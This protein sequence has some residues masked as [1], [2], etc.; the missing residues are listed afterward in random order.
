MTNIKKD[1]FQQGQFSQQTSSP[2]CATKTEIAEGRFPFLLLLL[3]PTKKRKKNKRPEGDICIRPAM[4]H[5]AG[6]ESAVSLAKA[7]GVTRIWQIL[8]GQ[9]G[10]T[11]V[12][13]KTTLII[14]SVLTTRKYTNCC[15]GK[16][17]WRVT[18]VRHN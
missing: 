6:V 16:F 2:I 7:V 11:L 18:Y 9:W 14:I 8:L 15:M 13:R 4:H 3:P 10:A 5:V 12:R 17:I 1:N